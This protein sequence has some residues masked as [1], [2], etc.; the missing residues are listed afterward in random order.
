[1][2]KKRFL[3]MIPICVLA[4]SALAQHE[5]VWED[6]TET[7][8]NT[9]ERDQ[10]EA[11]EQAEDEFQDSQQDYHD[12]LD[13]FRLAAWVRSNAWDKLLS[14]IRRCAGQWD[15]DCDRR[16]DA[17]ET[18]WSTAEDA[19]D[20]L[21]WNV[22]LAD[23][24]VVNSEKRLAKEQIGLE[25][26][27][28]NYES[29][30]DPLR[31]QNEISKC[32]EQRCLP[33]DFL[34]NARIQTMQPELETVGAHHAYAKGL[35][36]AG[37]TI[38]IED[39][40]VGI[41]IPEFEGRIDFA[42]RDAVGYYL[43]PLDSD[44][45]HWDGWVEER[46]GTPNTF[47]APDGDYDRTHLAA[48]KVLAQQGWPCH[49]DNGCSESNWWLPLLRE[50]TLPGD[51]E[52]W[53]AIPP[54]LSPEFSHGTKVA[55]VAAGRSFGIAPGATIV[56][57]AKNFR[58]SAQRARREEQYRLTQSDPSEAIFLDTAYSQ[59]VSL[60]Y[61]AFDI[62]NRS[63][64]VGVFDPVDV[65]DS[66]DSSTQWWGEAYRR[67]F[68]KTWRAMLQA[69]RHPDDRTIIVYAVGNSSQKH[70][71]LGADLPRHI[72][73]AR[74]HM[75]AVAALG[76]NPSVGLD[77]TLLEND[78]PSYAEY[79]NFCGPLPDDWDSARWGRHFCL[80]APG[81]LN[82]ASNAHA[83]EFFT[84]I[85]GT[86]FAAPM[87]SGA[88]A[89]LMEHFRGQ[90]GNSELVKRVLNTA[91]NSG[92]YAQV[93]IYGAGV[94]DL[95]A[96]LNPVGEVATGTHSRSVAVN[97]SVFFVPHATGDLGNRLANQGVEVAGLD[98]WG[99]PFW[100]TPERFLYVD[101]WE[102]PFE[103]SFAAEGDSIRATPHAGFTHGVAAIPVQSSAF[104][105]DTLAG[106]EIHLLRGDGRVGIEKA[107][108]D[109]YRWGY[110]KD[111]RSWMGGRT[112]GAFGNRAES[113]SAWIG[114]TATFELTDVWRATLSGTLA[115]GDV[116][117][118]AGTMLDVE[119]H[120][121][122]TWEA[123]FERRAD[124]I[125]TRFALSQP[126]RAETGAGTLTYMAGLKHGQPFYETA[127]VSLSP[128]RREV[129]LTLAHERPLGPGRLAAE[130]SFADNYRHRA[131]ITDARGGVA[132]RM[133]LQ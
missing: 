108:A 81:T 130:L 41:R 122:S 34:T 92:R 6:I 113:A 96:A 94:L 129:R 123:A 66:L 43:S 44:A 61:R 99:A 24:P 55:S 68:P 22:I 15:N 60:E 85:E 121:L 64:G 131:G 125:R 35:T 1:M 13:D 109:G 45:A 21:F 54:G 20:G 115:V 102:P 128:E 124:D 33:N 42:L 59:I 111:S 26:L 69:D 83:A 7:E 78:Q 25:F 50:G 73:D 58:D 38:A 62:I 46:G 116:W 16:V 8:Y 4:S 106:A 2:I 30:D 90:L 72:P 103:V 101:A 19:A 87:V 18:E 70:G 10:K 39:D 12:A 79:T 32:R 74:G 104:R 84:D 80:T 112:A 82:A 95:E 100:H 47:E 97:R 118:E 126:A 3:A 57:L 75:L 17:A 110:L 31:V 28:H 105:S 76:K 11:V 132:W 98:E 56:P 49:P 67:T 37:V 117:L 107:P 91:D 23:G 63:F 27:R 36:G 119:A 88:L 86:S 9:H 120:I 77:A 5:D 89:L 29:Q 14:E 48:M 127:S 65:I 53:F 133:L 52:R 93:E 71:G 40:L 114:R 51:P